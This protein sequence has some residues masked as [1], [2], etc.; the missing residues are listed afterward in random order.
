MY[1]PLPAPFACGLCGAIAGLIG[2]G[3]NQ[4]LPVWIGAAT[5]ASAGCV[6]CVCLFLF[7]VPEPPVAQIVRAAP[8]VIQ[9]IYIIEPTSLTGAPKNLGSSSII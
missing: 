3:F 9:N 8:T 4:C 6:I 7:D 1:N 2:G 5:G